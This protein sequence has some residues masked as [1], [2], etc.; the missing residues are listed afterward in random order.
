MR[1]L[2]TR[3]GPATGRRRVGAV[4]C[5]YFVAERCRSCTLLDQT[6]PEQLA[7]KQ[8]HA[9]AVLGPRPDLDWLPP[10]ASV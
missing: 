5:S 4:H 10:V 8:A 9:Q 7:A 2:V 6:Y 3:Q 1:A